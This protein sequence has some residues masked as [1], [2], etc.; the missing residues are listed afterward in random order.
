MHAVYVCILY[1]CI[2]VHISCIYM[3]VLCVCISCVCMSICIHKSMH[4]YIHMY[5]VDMYVCMYICICARI[6]YIYVYA[7]VYTL[8]YV[9][10]ICLRMCLC[11]CV[12]VVYTTKYMPNIFGTNLQNNQDFLNQKILDICPLKMLHI[13]NLQDNSKY[14]WGFPLAVENDSTEK[15]TQILSK[16]L[17]SNRNP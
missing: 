3:R 12:C 16:M 13:F 6:L 9:Y 7:Y 14:F 5:V 1:I 17:L 4:M 11:V 2:H 15:Y 10:C 8:V